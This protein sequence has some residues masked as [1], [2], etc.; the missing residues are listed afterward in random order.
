[1]TTDL[2]KLY[3]KYKL[4]KMDETIEMIDLSKLSDHELIRL[5]EMLR[6]DIDR[7]EEFDRAISNGSLRTFDSL[8]VSSDRMDWSMIRYEISRR[9]RQS[10]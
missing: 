5:G 1:M 4:R 3:Q 10:S 8:A 6:K 9:K 2:S 7:A